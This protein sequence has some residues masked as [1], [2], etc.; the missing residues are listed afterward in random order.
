MFDNLELERRKTMKYVNYCLLTAIFLFSM[1]QVGCLSGNALSTG[2]QL[3]EAKDYRGAIDAYQRVVDTNPGTPEARKAQIAI[4][5]L[6]VERM[7]R[8]EEGIK[9]YEAVIAEAPES[10][11]AAEAHYNLG[12]YYYQHKQDYDAAQVQ[13]DTIINKFPHLELSHRAQLMLAKSYE[14]GKK[15]EQAVEVFDNFANR[16][17][18]SE[19]AAVALANKARIQRTLIK[20]DEEAKRTYQFMVKKYGKL[21]S[22][23]SQIE[24]AKEELNKLNAAIPEPDNPEDTQIGRAMKRQEERRER[25]RPQGAEIS[26]AMKSNV[27]VEDSGFGISAEEVMRSFG[28]GTPVA[29]DDQGTYYDAELMIAGF[30]YG[31]EQYRDAGALLF[32]AIARAEADRAKLEPINYIRLS[33]CYRKLGMH[34]KAATV[35]KKAASRDPKVIDAII[36]T[37][38]NQYTNEEYEKAV[39]TFQSVIGINSSKDSELYWLIGKSYEKLGEYEKERDAFEMAVAK[40]PDDIDALQSLAEVLHYRLKDRKTAV[41]FQDIVNQKTDS[42]VTM[43]TLGDVCYK[44]G[45]YGKAQIK[46]KAAARTVKRQ[47]EQSGNVAEK[48]ILT[49]QYGYGT[50]L[51]A[52]ATFKKGRE[53]DAQK[54]IDTLT[55]EYPDHALLP[56]AKAEIALIKG[57]EQVAIDAFKEAIEKDPSS[58]IPVIA[59]GDFYVSKG[60]NDEAITLWETYLEKDKYNAKVMQRLKP[61]KESS[62]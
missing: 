39:E 8:P 31:D 56:Y 36:S 5:D 17:P 33:I 48:K 32:D 43:K 58:D 42:F 45:E 59:L 52:I 54:L 53:E 12:M 18:Q 47:L 34:Q 7:N 9:A 6:N 3:V 49:H 38:Q 26:P 4:A 37:G 35:L 27:V 16:N 60:Y 51:A 28:G 10:D 20:D 61:L 22:A 50:I 24:K 2:D 11:E 29:G 13:F 15:Y 1:T 41:I 30:F 57:D 44:H 55:A 23:Q 14:E 62:E 25:D 46:Y 40:N 21:D 19:R